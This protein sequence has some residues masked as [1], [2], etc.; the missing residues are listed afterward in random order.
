MV[1]W[2]L[3]RWLARLGAGTLYVAPGSPWENGI[4]VSFNGKLRDEL[5]KRELFS[6][7]REAEVPVKRWRVHYNR[8]RPH[9]ALGS[10]P[11]VP[12]PWCGSHRLIAGRRSPRREVTLQLDQSISAGHAMCFCRN[13]LTT[14]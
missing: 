6:T 11:P 1:V 13:G 5:L 2:K 12:R 14:T 9:S 3:R 8:V 7:L 4:C 10:R